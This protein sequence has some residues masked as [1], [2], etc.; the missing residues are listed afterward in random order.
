[1]ENISIIIFTGL[2]IG[3]VFVLVLYTLNRILKAIKRRKQQKNTSATKDT[4]HTTAEDGQK[5]SH[6]GSLNEQ[7]ENIKFCQSCL[8][9]L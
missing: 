6:C 3:G 7:F 2:F 8:Q 1:M 5:C 4:T 9:E